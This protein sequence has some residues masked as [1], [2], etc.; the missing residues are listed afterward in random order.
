MA[1]HVAIS[2][3]WLILS[4]HSVVGVNRTKRGATEAVRLRQQHT[5]SNIVHWILGP[6]RL[7]RGARAERREPE[8]ISRCSCEATYRTE[9]A[10]AALP[11]VGVMD[12]RKGTILELRNCIACGSTI[13][14]QVDLK[15]GA[16]KRGA[17]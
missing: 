12:F 13:S 17:K 15:K 5:A 16:R 4:D 6:F 3:L 10:W 14:R 7:D 2:R 8:W 1:E 9:S 11:Y